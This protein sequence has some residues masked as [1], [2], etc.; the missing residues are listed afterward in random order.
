M[1]KRLL[2]ASVV[3]VL[4]TAIFTWSGNYK[5]AAVARIIVNL[6]ENNCHEIRFI[7]A[8]TYRLSRSIVEQIDY[9]AV[10]IDMALVEGGTFT[11]GCTEEQGD[12]C[13]DDEKPAHNVTLSDFY[14]G[15]YEVTQRQWWKVMGYNPSS[16]GFR[17]NL[18]LPVHNVTWKEAQT[19]IKKLNRAT[20]KK[21][22][23]PTEAEWEY[24]ARGGKISKGYRYS[25]GDDINNV[26]W[27]GYNGGN[28]IHPV[29]TKQPNELGIYDMSGNVWEWVS[30]RI[31]WS[32][33]KYGAYDSA[34]QT[35]P[36]GTPSGSLR[37]K[38]G[39]GWFNDEAQY[40]RVA[41]RAGLKPGDWDIDQG[42]RLARDT[43]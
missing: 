31:T 34:S 26:A 35:N 13:D 12:K 18:S 21:Y 38:R 11:M 14:I 23:L 2:I 37:V 36:A 39:G 32:N 1:Y 25:G 43:D 41:N 5:N 27:F 7:G 40:L 15:R 4:A 29:G 10:N 17:G 3:A 33:D 6:F 8:A 16:R 24:A 42:F 30:D 19:F 20:G 28:T 22:R 9:P